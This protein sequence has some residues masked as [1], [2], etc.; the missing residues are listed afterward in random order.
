VDGVSSGQ[1][2]TGGAG[3]AGEPN[4]IVKIANITGRTATP[5]AS[6][7]V[8]LA[9]WELFARSG[10]VTPFLLPALSTVLVRVFEDV[11]G[12]ELFILLGL[13]F[14]RALAGFLIGVVIAVPLGIMIARSRAFNWFFDPVI[15]ITN[16]T[17]KVAFL[18]IFMIW[19][20][21]GDPSK[22]I[23]VILLVFYPMVI[24]AIGGTQSVDKQLVWSARSLGA[25]EKEV[26]WQVILPAALPQIITGLQIAV[27]LALIVSIVAEF[28]MGGEG[29]GG[30][31][32]VAQRFA[33]S[34]GVFA[35]IVEIAVSGAI[36]IKTLEYFRRRLLAWHPETSLT[37]A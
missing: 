4:L 14:Y 16:P 37:T 35:G 17:P 10:V 5:F 33:D 19:F 29:I 13:T 21:L 25:S 12:G 32:L 34:P 18:P 9:G 31:L 3:K 22:I 6:T 1:T 28:L 7:I 15:S 30:K 24:A 2:A 36:V 8:F 23:S 26:L 20:G 27:P 11:I